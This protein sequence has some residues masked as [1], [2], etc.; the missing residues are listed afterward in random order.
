V[1][2][3]FRAEKLIGVQYSSATL[4]AGLQ[5]PTEG[6]GTN[7]HRLSVEAFTGGLKVFRRGLVAHDPAEIAT[8]GL[9]GG[10]IAGELS[11]ETAERVAEA[12]PRNRRQPRARRAD[13]GR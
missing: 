2:H 11:R 1:A 13:R 4:C 8:L 12:A 10:P 9:D 7:P 6:V 5:E 3:Y